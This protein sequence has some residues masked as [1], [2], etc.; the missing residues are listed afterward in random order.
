[1]S[2]GPELVRIIDSIARDKDIDREILF[3]SLEVAMI[4]AARKKY[5]EAEFLDVNIGRESGEIIGVRDGITIDTRYLGRIAAQTAKQVM[6]QKIREAEQDRTFDEFAERVGQL[7]TGIVQRFEGENVI[8]DL[9]K[10]EAI[11]PRHERVRTET[12]HVGDR[13]RVVV[14][15]VKKVGHRVRI[16]LSRTHPDLIRRL[17]EL[18]IPEIADHIIEIK[19]LARE[20]GHRTKLAVVSYDS[21]VDCVG[22]CVGIRGSRIRNIIDELN[23]EKIDIIRWNESPEILI[24][25]ALKPAEIQSITLDDDT[26]EAIVSVAEDQLSLAIGKRGQNVRLAARLTGWDV[27][28]VGAGG[29]RNSP[30]PEGGTPESLSEAEMKVLDQLRGDTGGGDKSE[31]DAAAAAAAALRG[32]AKPS[33]ATIDRDALFGTPKTAEGTPGEMLE[34]RPVSPKSAQESRATEFALEQDE[35]APVPFADLRAEAAAAEAAAR[36]EEA[37]AAANADK[38]SVADE[39]SDEVA[40]DETGEAQGEETVAEAANELAEGTT[41]EAAKADDVGADEPADDAGVAEATAP[42]EGDEEED[43][44][45]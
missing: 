7:V 10:A 41:D 26:H 30:E 14:T 12:C 11:L 43:K 23:G 6:I 20:P 8:A 24:M 27:N 9:S 42:V 39:P 40:A 4:A 16:V 45:P 22:A 18:E 17:F 29:D 28:I 36:K 25:N 21:K 15:D 2:G 37:E 34:L 31:A 38:A 32:D 13:I 35:G 5:D 44:A 19:A 3:E 33:E 1:M